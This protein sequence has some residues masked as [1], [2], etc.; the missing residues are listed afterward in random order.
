MNHMTGGGNDANP[1]HRNPNANC[2][3]WGIKNSSLTMNSAGTAKAVGPSAMY[4]QSYVY[5]EGEYTGKPPSQE[6]PGI[7]CFLFLY[8]YKYY[9][10]KK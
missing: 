2:A 10:P 7:Q 5:S 9:M 1:K 6:F 8:I 4:T 3:V